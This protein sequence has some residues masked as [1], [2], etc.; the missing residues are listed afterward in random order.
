[1][2]EIIITSL[3]SQH[4]HQFPGEDLLIE[5]ELN[6]FICNV[7][8]KLLKGIPLEILKAKNVQDTNSEITTTEKIKP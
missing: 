7:N 1:M 3:K 8:T 2:A 4:T 6:L 5:V